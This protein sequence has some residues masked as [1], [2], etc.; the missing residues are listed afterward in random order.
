MIGLS[1]VDADQ[2]RNIQLLKERA[3]LDIPLVYGNNL[4]AILAIDKGAP[5][6][7]AFAEGFKA[8]SQ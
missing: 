5:G 7:R 8:W 2:E 4:R 1:N 3:W 6:E